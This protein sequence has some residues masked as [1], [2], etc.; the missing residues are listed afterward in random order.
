LPEEVTSHID[1]KTVSVD[2]ES[3]VSREFQ[4]FFSDVVAQMQFMD[5]TFREVYFL[6]EHK[7]GCK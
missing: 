2:L 4:E 7:K 3:Y 6:F 1:L 5:G